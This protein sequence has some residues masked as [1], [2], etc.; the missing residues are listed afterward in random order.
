MNSLKER[1]LDLSR[2]VSSPQKWIGLKFQ[3][4]ALLKASSAAGYLPE[5]NDILVLNLGPGLISV[6]NRRSTSAKRAERYRTNDLG[7]LPLVSING[8]P[9]TSEN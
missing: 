8:V 6:R 2:A 4:E 3:Y 5:I 9:H 1:G 7:R